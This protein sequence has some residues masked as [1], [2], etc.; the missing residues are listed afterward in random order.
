MKIQR[1]KDYNEAGLCVLHWK[2]FISRMKWTT[3]GEYPENR[4]VK[5]NLERK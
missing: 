2:L 5:K 4:T 1:K 3:P